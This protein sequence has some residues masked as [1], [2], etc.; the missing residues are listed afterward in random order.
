MSRVLMATLGSLGDLHPVLAIGLELRRRG[1]AVSYATS[2]YYRGRIESLG[3]GFWPLRPD[4]APENP[5]IAP[6]ISQFMDARTGAERLLRGFLFP[7]I[8]ATYGD[9]MQA[10]MVGD[11]VDLLVSGEL[12]Y[13]APLIAEKT[14]IPWASCITTPMSFF[15]AYEP[16]VMPPLPKLSLW[17]HTLGPRFNRW[18]IRLVKFITRS[19]SKPLRELR[20]ELGL[21]VG[22]DPIY[23]GKHSPQL[24]LALFSRAMAQPQPDWPPNTLATGFP[25]YDGTTETNTLPQEL[26]SFLA[27]GEPP[28]VFT[29]GSAAVFDAGN[30]YSES[31]KAARILKRRGLLLL[32]R[33]PPPAPLPEGVLAF[34]YA[35]FTELFPRASAIVHQGGIG[36]T[37][38][39]LR[40]GRPMLVMPYNYDQPD[41]AARMARLGVG[42]IVSRKKY[43]AEF[44]AH[45]LGELLTNA[46]YARAATEL[47]RQVRNEC[48]ARTAAEALERLLATGEGP[49]QLHSSM[50][51]G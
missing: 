42:R 37:A 18:T 32:G 4:V 38:Q 2:E 35:G 27:T 1:H 17:L 13:P 36:T 12:V 30:F 45:E 47:G 44:V 28:I 25:F 23:E 41:N 48:G 10:V 50:R 39:A 20:S 9:L 33:N 5:E 26:L 34:G 7:R 49:R 40:S 22:L 31:A 8:R 3:F 14:G 11:G 21:S 24:V 19:W 6:L 16:P 46:N 51:V 43:L 29:L 15:S